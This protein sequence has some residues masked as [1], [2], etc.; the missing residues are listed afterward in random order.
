MS[1][2]KIKF[3]V[4]THNESVMV[5]ICIYI[6]QIYTYIMASYYISRKS[7][8]NRIVL[9]TSCIQITEMCVVET[10]FVLYM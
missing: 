3:E 5:L 9:N 1:L 6:L 10:E 7:H 8:S 2:H 4:I